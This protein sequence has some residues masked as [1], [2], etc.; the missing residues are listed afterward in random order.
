MKNENCPCCP[1][2]CPKD[3]L[4]CG[5][6]REYF[7]NQNG[8]NRETKTIQGQIIADLRKCGNSLHHNRDL[9]SEEFLSNLSEKELNGL[10]ELLTKIK[11]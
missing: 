3:N 1:N 4:N 6:G 8:N 2:N 10:H 5:R 9:N 11:C 7:N